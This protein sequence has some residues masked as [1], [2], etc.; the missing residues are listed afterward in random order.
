[1]ADRLE[2]LAVRTAIRKM[3]GEGR[4]SICTI[5]QCIKQLG[6]VSLSGLASMRAYRILHTLHCVKFAEMEPE[7][8][9][10]IPTLLRE[11]FNGSTAEDF[12]DP[13][14]FGGTRTVVVNA[15]QTKPGFWNRLTGGGK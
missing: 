11:V 13:D 10:A 9:N 4:I 1:M 3:V 6:I 7:L 14:L 12:I 8:R 2:M 5:D 15:E